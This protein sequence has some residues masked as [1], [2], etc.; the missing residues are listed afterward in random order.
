M[1]RKIAMLLTALF[2]SAS[3]LVGCGGEGGQEGGQEGRPTN[4]EA[5]GQS[6]TT[7]REDQIG[8]GTTG[9]QEVKI[10]P[11][12]IE[13]VDPE[14]RTLVLKQTQGEPMTFRIVQRARITLD[15]KEAQLEDLKEGQNAQVRYVV[16][17]GKNRARVVKAFSA[18]EGDTTG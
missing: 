17:E 2:V 7:D 16:R 13:S 5:Q 3:A 14:R 4:E 8:G 10:A 1:S 15:G 9:A 11:G 18:G 6:G 12:T